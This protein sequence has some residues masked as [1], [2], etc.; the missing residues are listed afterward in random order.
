M[1][2]EFWIIVL[3][4]FYIT[5]LCL[6]IGQLREQVR[7]E[8]EKFSFHLRYG[9]K[10]PEGCRLHCWQCP[11]LCNACFRYFADKDKAEQEEKER[12]E[13]ELAAK[14]KAEREALARA[15]TSGGGQ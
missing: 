4:L 15:N 6:K 3:L 7:V 10:F 9:T 13:R 2:I 8:N 1:K 5:M 14:Q 12:M 11:Y